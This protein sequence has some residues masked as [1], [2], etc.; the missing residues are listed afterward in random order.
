MA[1]TEKS[2]LRKMSY[3]IEVRKMESYETRTL[4]RFRNVIAV[5]D[6]DRKE[7]LALAPGCT[8]T[9]VPTGVDTEQYQP[10]PSVAGGPPRIVFTGSMDWEPN[11]DAVEY[12][13]RD[14]F[15]SILAQFPD[16]RFQIVGRNPYPRVKK[17]ASASVEVTGTVPSVSEYLRTA[18]VVIVPLRIGGGTRLKIFE[19]MAMK[20]AL[21]STSIGAE[22]LDVTSGK[23]CLLADDA[24]SFATAILALLRDPEL[25]RS[26]ENNAAALAARY[27]WSQIARRFADALGEAVT[28]AQG[29]QRQ[30]P[31][32]LSV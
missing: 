12:F 32:A 5:S 24:Q 20:K 6:H 11:I 3:R 14:I 27:D 21:V 25:R 15:P 1:D 19:A 29:A 18:T 2:A 16:A 8:I 30:T 10:A 17:L 28:A 13:C 23:D 31:A 9:V 26:Y 7:M 4:R 22:G